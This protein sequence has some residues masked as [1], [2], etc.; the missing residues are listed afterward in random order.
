MGVSKRTHHASPSGPVRWRLW[1]AAASEATARLGCGVPVASPLPFSERARI[2]PM[3]SPNEAAV[4]FE[5]RRTEAKGNFTDS[6]VKSS[7]GRLVRPLV[8]TARADFVRR[9]NLSDTTTHV[10]M[11]QSEMNSGPRTAWWIPSRRRRIRA[12]RRSTSF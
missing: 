5:M 8:S 7:T 6:E 2:F 10:S 4:K 11:A 12:R 1:L 3:H 9:S